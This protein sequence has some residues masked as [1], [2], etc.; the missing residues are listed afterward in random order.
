[1]NRRITVLHSEL[2]EI[3]GEIV[4]TR[5]EIRG[6]VVNIEDP[7]FTTEGLMK[8]TNSSRRTIQTWRDEG[9]SEYSLVKGKIF[10]KLS[11]IYKMLDNNLVK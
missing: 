4:Q 10:Y 5:K 6:G 7:L 2:Q 1:M 9:L 3:L 11:A 8:F